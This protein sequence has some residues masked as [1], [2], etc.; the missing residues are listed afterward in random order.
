M[1]ARQSR[2]VLWVSRHTMTENQR[3]DLERIMGGPV[4]LD[5]WSDTV[6]DVK[7]LRPRLREADAVAAVL[8]TE[9][10]AELLKIAGKCPVLQA[11]SARVPTGRFTVQPGG[12]A[13]REF[14]FVHQGWQQILEVRIRTRAL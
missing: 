2:R 14:A 10:L 7:E 5:T 4:E 13:E 11:K 8:P 3:Q 1:K 9:K 6:R 12:T